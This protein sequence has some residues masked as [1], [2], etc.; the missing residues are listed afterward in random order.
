[1][2]SIFQ[3][4]KRGTWWIK[5]Y[6]DGKQVYHSLNTTDKREARRKKRE[7]EGDEAKGGSLRPVRDAPRA[8]PR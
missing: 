2:A 6:V 7:V 5:Y 1:M 8:V 4:G 3:R